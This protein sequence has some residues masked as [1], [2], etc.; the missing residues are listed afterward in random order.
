[1]TTKTFRL[2]LYVKGGATYSYYSLDGIGA[3]TGSIYA[4]NTIGS[5]IG[6]LFLGFYLFPRISSSEIFIGL[7]FGLLLLAL[8]V[9]IFER[10]HLKLS[11]A[12]LPA[13]LLS[14]PELCSSSTKPLF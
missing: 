9:A 6:T 12:I 3:S 5:V 14:F 7:G 10:K 11:T 2:R 4:I 13:A 8:I 1:M